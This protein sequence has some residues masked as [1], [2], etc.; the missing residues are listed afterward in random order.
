MNPKETQTMAQTKSLIIDGY[1][2][3]VKPSAKLA[4]LVT[5]DVISVTTYDGKLIP[6]EEFARAAVP[7]GFERN[8]SSIN[9]GRGEAVGPSRRALLGG[10][11][12]GLA[13]L[14]ASAVQPATARVGSAAG[15]ALRRRLTKPPPPKPVHAE[16]KPHDVVVHRSRHPEAAA[17]IDHAQ[18]QGQPSVLHVD[19]AG[20]D[21]RRRASTGSV[22]RETSPGRGYDRD[23][24][25]PAFTREGGANANVRFIPA[26]DNRG[27]GSAMGRQING[28]KEGEK[29]RV[30]VAD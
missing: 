25:P 14:G 22:N 8:L 26:R 10:A 16:G 28:V 19:R 23:E 6:R 27:A 18:R 21:A 2:T 11:L 4:D 24:Y 9:K 29:I 30:I 13:L 5:P 1:V 3:E 7:L 20:A 17:H 12:A 15:A